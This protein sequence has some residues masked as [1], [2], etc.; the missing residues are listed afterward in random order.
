MQHQ[1]KTKGLEA[2]WKIASMSFHCIVEENEVWCLQSMMFIA[3]KATPT[4]AKWNLEDEAVF[5]S[6][7]VLF[8]L[9][10]SLLG[11]TTHNQ[12]GCSL[13][14][15][16]NHLP[17]ISGNS[18]LAHPHYSTRYLFLLMVLVIGP[19]AFTVSSIPSPFCIVCCC[20]CYYLLYYY[21]YLL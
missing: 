10:T 17:V 19:R 7:P 13:L 3:A 16:L 5:L 11:R 6:L 14:H 12:G 1:S 9:D 2:S 4:Q 15:L 8:L 21:Y 18:P 20:H